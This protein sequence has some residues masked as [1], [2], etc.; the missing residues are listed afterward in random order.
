MNRAYF[1]SRKC[2]DIFESSFLA[3]DWEHT[4]SQSPV[5]SSYTIYLRHSPEPEYLK[6]AHQLFTLMYAGIHLR[7]LSPS[8]ALIRVI[9]LSHVPSSFSLFGSRDAFFVQASPRGKP[10]L[11]GALHDTHERELLWVPFSTWCSR[12]VTGI[13]KWGTKMV[14]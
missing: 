7:T 5:A 10:S 14:A 6:A 12:H 8:V 11:L 1:G 3:A 13:H 9:L 4:C 2:L